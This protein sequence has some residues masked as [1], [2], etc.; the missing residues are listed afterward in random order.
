M[1]E[2]VEFF[3]CVIGRFW[4]R[5]GFGCNRARELGESIVVIFE[6]EVGA[7]KGVFIMFDGDV[8]REPALD[9]GIKS[10]SGIRLDG[11]GIDFG[12]DHIVSR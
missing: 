2:K 3:R 12:W 4:E 11:G 9:A 5:G 6:D 1:V 7:T 10:F 8:A